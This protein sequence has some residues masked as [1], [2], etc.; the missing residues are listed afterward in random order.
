MKAAL[1]TFVAAGIAATAFAGGA[2]AQD[3]YP[4]RPIDMVITFG[5]GGGSDTMGRTAAHLAE[6]ELGVAVPASNVSG[7]SGNAGLTR[8]LTSPADGYTL[9]TL[10]AL[11]VSS[12]AA[13][14]GVGQPDQFDVVGVLQSSPSMLFVPKDSPHKSAEELLAFA[15]ANPKALKVATSGFGTMDDVTLRYLTKQGDAMTNVPF[16]KPAERYASTVGAHTDAIYEEP[17]DVAQFVQSGDLVP[18]LVF[19]DE[20]HKDFPDV[21]AS[22]ELGLD[23][24]GL[25]NFRTIAVKK[26][27]P[28]EI[29]ERLHKVF[30]DVTATQEWHDFCAKTYTCTENMSVEDANAMVE[31]FYKKVK[32]LLAQPS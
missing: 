3:A 30:A 2:L 31:T 12:W 16:A 5:P 10:I 21:P 15:K 19:A 25:D 9:G 18:V 27:T 7:A 23:I 4:E 17:G 8:V 20:R 14:L 28:P 1:G 11:T 29:V 13:G 26:G 22:K 6:K 32:D 24:S